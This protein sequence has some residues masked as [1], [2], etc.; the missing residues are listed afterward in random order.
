VHVVTYLGFIKCG[1][2]DILT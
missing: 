1:D 2:L